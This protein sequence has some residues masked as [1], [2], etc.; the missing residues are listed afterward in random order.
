MKRRFTISV[1]FLAIFIF[2]VL[3]ASVLFAPRDF[4]TST[5]FTVNKGTGLSALSADLAKNNIIK[6]PFWFKVFSVLTG[7][8]KGIKSG[9]YALKDKEGVMSIAYRIS[10]GDFR[11]VPIKL[12]IPE[13]LNIFEIG[14]LV[15]KNFSKISEKDFIEQSKKDEGYLFPDT[16]L[17]L[18]NISV[19]DIIPVLKSNFDKRIA[20]IK[21][22]ITNYK[23]PLADIIKLA[24]I[25]EEEARTTESRKVVAGILWKRLALNMPL[26]VDSSFKY[27]NGKG[28]AELTLADL[29]IDSPYNSYLY[30]GLP[31]TPIANPGLDSI[32][33]T[34]TPTKTD[35]LYFL[36]D[37]EGD[38]HYARTYAEH[39]QNKELYLK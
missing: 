2:F 8:T 14:K 27:I 17:F 39:L 4:P 11:L 15:A 33:A 28:T 9:D 25:V 7:G 29:K 38:M 21:N 24:S 10:K 36:T 32:L 6:S 37:K 31:P 22:E 5:V 3:S 26:Q 18:P 30:K 23:K 34:V 12:T 13:G 19:V 16:Y 1:L 35:Y 20:T